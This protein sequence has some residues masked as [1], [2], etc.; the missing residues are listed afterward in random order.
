MARGKK[1]R[2]ALYL[3][4]ILLVLEVVILVGLYLWYQYNRTKKKYYLGV[5]I[6]NQLYNS[7]P[8]EFFQLI[9][10]AIIGVAISFQV[11]PSI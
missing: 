6:Y 11:S 2:V 4:V 1:E 9:G 3:R 7:F 10:I 5:Q 8:F